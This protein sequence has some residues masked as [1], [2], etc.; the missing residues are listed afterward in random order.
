M[1]IENSRPASLKN[2]CLGFYLKW[3]NKFKWIKFNFPKVCDFLLVFMLQICQAI[4]ILEKL[5]LLLPDILT[6]CLLLN[7]EVHS[8]KR[9]IHLNIYYLW[10]ETEFDE[11]PI[12]L[13]NVCL[14]KWLLLWH[15]ASENK[16]L[17]FMII[18][19]YIYIISFSEE[20]KP[21]FAYSIAPL[22]CKSQKT[23]ALLF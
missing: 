11:T 18:I 7:L 10:M 22:I 4:K 9:K 19:M 20:L 13:T 16:L 17:L 8:W 6:M 12:Q 1:S 23:A 14:P 15:Y 2:L 3:K 5:L 21:I